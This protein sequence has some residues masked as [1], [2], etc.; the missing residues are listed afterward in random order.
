LITRTAAEEYLAK[1]LRDPAYAQAYEAA[2][3]RITFVDSVMRSLDEER[4]RRG[5]SKA[6]LARSAGLKPE[7]VRRL[8][9][10]RPAN[11]TLGTLF[12]LASALDVEIQLVPSV[13]AQVG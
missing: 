2:K 4:Q 3:A 6:A 7:V 9:S 10:R 11:P 8:F 12:V 5:L 1:R 13:T